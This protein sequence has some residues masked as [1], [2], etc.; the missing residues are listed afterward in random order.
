MTWTTFAGRKSASEEPKKCG[1]VA[2]QGVVDRGQRFEIRTRFAD[3]DL[4]YDQIAV[5]RD[6][7][8]IALARLAHPLKR[9]KSRADELGVGTS[10]FPW[11][12]GELVGTHRDDKHVGGLSAFHGGLLPRTV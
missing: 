6:A 3:G 7:G 1:Q 11:A 12:C 10:G 5:I 4:F 8:L 9:E 2:E